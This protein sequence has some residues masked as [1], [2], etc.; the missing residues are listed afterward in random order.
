MV[1]AP[2]IVVFDVNVL[3]PFALRDVLMCAAAAGFDQ[4]RG[5]SRILAPVA[6]DGDDSKARPILDHVPDETEEVDG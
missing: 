2:F 5:S 3:F 4:T 1:P 6:S